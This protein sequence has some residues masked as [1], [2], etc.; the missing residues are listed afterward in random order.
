MGFDHH[1]FGEHFLDRVGC[2]PVL[3][4][5][6]FEWYPIII[7]SWNLFRRDLIFLQGDLVVAI[8][9][10]L[11]LANLLIHEEFDTIK[12]VVLHISVL[13]RVIFLEFEVLR[14]LP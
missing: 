7:S 13:M 8:A 3:Y 14:M 6:F 12:W 5:T 10:I 2:A 1:G 9:I 4:L 11:I